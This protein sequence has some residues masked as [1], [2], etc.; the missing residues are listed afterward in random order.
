MKQRAEPA[1][2]HLQVLVVRY[3][4][5]NGSRRANYIAVPFL[6]DTDYT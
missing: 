5:E 4:I 2:Q 6:A 1:V 3:Y